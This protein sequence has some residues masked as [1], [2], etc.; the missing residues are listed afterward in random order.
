MTKPKPLL[1]FDSTDDVKAESLSYVDCKSGACE[2]SPEFSVRTNGLE[3]ID[4]G[5]QI[6]SFVK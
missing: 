1:N 3:A 6:R 2:R 5:R 4:T